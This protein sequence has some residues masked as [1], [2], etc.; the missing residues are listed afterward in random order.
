MMQPTDLNVYQGDDWSGLVNVFNADGSPADLTPY[1]AQAQ[2]RREPADADPVIVADMAPLIQLPNQ[3][4]LTIPNAE[5]KQ[6]TGIYQWDLQ[7]TNG[8][9]GVITTILFG[10]VYVKPEITR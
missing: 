3:I 9:P 1:T 2:V 10:K 7:L 6:M 8:S 4:L 5:S